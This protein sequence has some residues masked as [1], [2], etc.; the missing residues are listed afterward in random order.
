MGPVGRGG[1]RGPGRAGPTWLA[2]THA[3][4]SRGRLSH[5]SHSGPV[6]RPHGSEPASK[7]STHAPP[8]GPVTLQNPPI[9]TQIS[10]HLPI[11]AALTIPWMMYWCDVTTPHQADLMELVAIVQI[12]NSSAPFGTLKFFLVSTRIQLFSVRFMRNYCVP[13]RLYCF[14]LHNDLLYIKKNSLVG[15]RRWR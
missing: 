10:N 2:H 8:R 11:Y 5:G 13:I 14:V 9:Q 4:P 7:E 3:A 15:S 1:D 12:S 6:G